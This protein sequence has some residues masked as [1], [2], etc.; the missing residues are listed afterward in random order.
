MD[1]TKPT[2]SL[3]SF[4]LVGALIQC[5]PRVTAAMREHYVAAVIVDWSYKNQHNQSLDTVFK[6]LIY[7]EYEAGFQK[8]KPT[9]KWSGILGPT[10]R[11]EVG[12][13]MKVHFKNMADKPLTIHPQGI[14]YG[15]NAEGSNYTDNT[16]PSEKMDDSV[17]PGQVYI[18]K[19]EITEDIGPKEADP[20]C[21]TYTYYSH[22]NMVQDFNSGL[23]GALLICKKGSLNDEGTQK[24]FDKD[25][26]LMFAV[27]DESKSWRKVPSKEHRSVMYTINGYINGTMPDAEACI[28]DS[29]SWHLIGMSSKPEL[30]SIH[31]F[32]QTL[33]Q[34]QH[35][36]SVISLVGTASTTANMTV[37]ENG[38]WLISSLVE[39]HLQAGMHSYLNVQSCKHQETSKHK[40]AL[41][42]RYIKNWDY[43]IAAEEMLWDYAP[44]NPENTDRLHCQQ[45]TK[46]K[47]AV[48]RQYTDKTFTKRLH[49]PIETGL[50]GPVIRAQ[51]RDTITIV[52]KNM[53]TQ[54]YSIYPHGVSLQK[55]FEGASYPPDLKGNRTQNQAVMPGET[56]TYYW[57]IRETDEPTKYDAQC[58]TR[59]YHSAVDVTKD[60]ASGL[61]GPLLI[62]KSMSLNTR[63]VQKKA[64]LE[65]L[66]TFAVFDENKSWYQEENS[67]KSC[68]KCAKQ[69]HACLD[70]SNI[71]HTINGF[72]QGNTLLGFCRDQVVQWHVSS[73]GVQDEIIGVHLMG[74]SF[75]HN[76]KN[77]DVV[78]LFP[79]TGESVSVE[80]DNIGVW[81]F[82]TLGFSKRNQGMKLRFRD[83]KC[84][85]DEDYD[86]PEPP[87]FV[88]SKEN[89]P[90]ANPLFDTNGNEEKRKEEMDY[91]DYLVK[92]FNIRS[93]R[94]KTQQAE[95]EQLDLTALAIEETYSTKIEN[96]DVSSSSSFSE[97]IVH[98]SSESNE[99]SKEIGYISEA[100]K[101]LHS[102]V[103]AL[104][105]VSI[106]DNG[107]SVGFSNKNLLEENATEKHNKEQK[108]QV[109][110]ERLNSTKEFPGRNLTEVSNS[111][112]FE[113][114]HSF[115]QVVEYIDDFNISRKKSILDKEEEVQLIKSAP[116]LANSSEDT[117]GKNVVKRHAEYMTENTTDV[118]LS[119]NYAQ[120]NI[121]GEVNSRTNSG[122]IDDYNKNPFS[123]QPE[124]WT[125]LSQLP[126]DTSQLL[127]G[128][129][130]S[131]IETNSLNFPSNHTKHV[132]NSAETQ[133][134]GT[135][136]PDKDIEDYEDTEFRD[137]LG[138]QV[139]EDILKAIFL[140]NQS[141]KNENSKE[142][143]NL[144]SAEESYEDSLEDFRKMS[145]K[146]TSNTTHQDHLT[147]NKNATKNKDSYHKSKKI[148]VKNDTLSTGSM[149]MIR[150]KKRVQ[151]RKPTYQKDVP[152]LNGPNHTRPMLE[153]NETTPSNKSVQKFISE[154]GFSPR[155]FKPEVIIGVSR[156]AEGDYVE[157]DETMKTE[158]DAAASYEYVEYEKP[159]NTGSEDDVNWFTNPNE[160]TARYL[161][162]TKGNKRNYYIAA[163]EVQWDYSGLKSSTSGRPAS[164]TR[165]TLYTKVIFRQY[166][167]STFKKP[168][169]HGEY[170]E[171][172]GILGPI[173]RAEVDD[174]IQ[175]TFKNLASRPYSLHAHG[176]SYEKSSEGSSYDDET[177]DWLKK[178]DAV[179]PGDTHVYVWYAT[180]QSGP[181]QEGSACKTWV[182]YSGVN[183]ERD[184]HSG[185]IGPLLICKNGTLDKYNNRPLDAREF[186]MLFM[187]FEEEKSWYFEKNSRKICSEVTEKASDA[188]KCHKFHAINGIIYNLQGLQMYKKEL[189]RWHLLNMGGPKDVHVV[190]FHGQ[191]FVEKNNQEYQHGVYPLLP[192][193][194][195]TIEMRPSRVGQ[196]LLDTEVAEYQQAGM[197]TKFEII[198]GECKLPMGLMTGAISDKQIT[199]SHYIDFWE[200]RLARLNNAG[201]YNAWST[202]M[203]KTSLPWIQVDMQKPVL[204]SGIKTQ[205]ASKYF[206]PFY[207]KEFFVAYSKDKRKWTAFRGNSTALQ[208][209]FDG[210]IDATNIKENEFDPPITARYIRVYPTKYYNRPT[211]RM[212]LLGCEKEGCS[213]PL[214]MENELIKD[215]QITASSYKSSWYSTW[216]PSYARLNK[217]GNINSWQA[218]SNNNQQWLNIDLLLTKKITG[219]IT[220]GAKWLTTEMFVQSYTVL[221]SENGKDWKSYPDESTSMEKV[222]LGN[223]NSS[224]HVKNYFN[225]PIFARFLRIVPKTWNQNIAM[226]LEIVGCNV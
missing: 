5:I 18:Y 134:S 208:K 191:T 26:I 194:F 212:E 201:S 75:R 180:K 148:K 219:I 45:K 22:E 207:V 79:M 152:L 147:L 209:L 158:G 110:E 159:Y 95:E 81:L 136:S 2:C 106:M 197:Q 161:R 104:V 204:I 77:E 13:T 34:N 156:V 165:N 70:N 21:L 29:I 23:I 9:S 111:T 162:S 99:L 119:V 195:A 30:F 80:M 32:G 198:E 88:D 50:L 15:K 221:H 211:L 69:D 98:G 116:M 17:L 222:F 86:Y 185:L 154:T 8:A 49:N 131:F 10:L 62:C 177:P 166:H 210:N 163:E 200:P 63:G 214:G 199:A 128:T 178:D 109:Q 97:K 151:D 59:M 38:K 1:H 226:R 60:I 108:S 90:K 57:N 94:N 157:Y 101:D 96:I 126:N 48:Y 91:N 47:K 149:G 44:T 64:D 122:I 143:Q 188:M 11:A 150:R 225:P 7:R 105:E 41:Q 35:K 127:N 85:T 103:L 133:L 33:E 144:V 113:M 20:F 82:G 83:A 192:G 203:N 73:V 135:N 174:V 115:F 181:E 112:D 141:T 172:L 51:V 140:H 153:V 65:Q 39:K 186:I 215:E 114:E 132:N 19:W 125:L 102:E 196:W 55:S 216:K 3:L 25:Y 160:I 42:K 202:E 170:E 28:Y 36:V 54:P 217:Q 164:E 16:F 189:V 93:F 92:E 213:I 74:H 206:K 107:V 12:D 187:T 173:I 123:Q 14:A 56:V 37:S 205:G 118:Y 175:V 146:V 129:L 67:Q 61:I 168:D 87:I 130:Q 184:I 190:H 137:I 68:N 43:F 218:K 121:T 145:N 220:Q 182:Y 179:N 72:A 142:K 100:D 40:L 6:K 139:L 76:G 120:K 183:P 89:I 171:H 27:F 31:F 53:A 66:A 193:S 176:V 46:Y 155:G 138:P 224:G 78:N 169:V 84:I 124:N 117:Q 71:M 24:H 223:V 58:L 4:L 52:F 167:D